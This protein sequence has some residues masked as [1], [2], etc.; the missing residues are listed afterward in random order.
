[1]TREVA[2][3]SQSGVARR[4]GRLGGMADVPGSAPTV[5]E[6][7]RRRRR[8]AYKRA[9]AAHERAAIVHEEATAFFVLHGKI[10]KASYHRAAAEEAHRRARDAQR[11]A[12]AL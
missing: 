7:H 10:D 12:D 5:S 6:E 11:T 2:R 4:G 9:A 1:M 8:D 3:E